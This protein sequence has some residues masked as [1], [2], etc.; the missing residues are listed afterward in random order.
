M[1]GLFL[2]GCWQ[3]FSAAVN[4]RAFLSYGL[5][6]EIGKYWTCTGLVMGALFLCV[7][8]ADLFDPDDVQVLAGVAVVGAIPVAVYYLVIYRKLI[9]HIIVRREVSGLIKSKHGS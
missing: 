8:L 3:L 2:M 7:P 9:D 6:V 1:A 5:P 4:T